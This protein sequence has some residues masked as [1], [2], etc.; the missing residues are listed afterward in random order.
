MTERPIL[1]SGEMVKAILEG[2][3]TQT[4]RI[5]KFKA[6]EPGL[7]FGW[8]GL[9]VGNYC[10]DV[11]ASGIVLQARRGDGCWEDKTYPLHCP[12]GQPGDR[13]WVRETWKI[14]S[15]WEGMPMDF[16]YKADGAICEENRSGEF[17]PNYE[18]WFERVNW[19]AEKYL[20]K[21]N[22][23]Q[24]EE[25]NYIWSADKSPLPWQPSIFMPRWAS[26]LTLEIVK[27]RVERVQEI[28]DSDIMAEGIENCQYA[29][30]PYCTHCS[31]HEHLCNRDRFRDLWDSI[32]AKRGYSWESNPWVWVIEFKRIP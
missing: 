7:N 28:S 14:A 31:G 21:S 11:P 19:N 17:A 3:K 32:N 18:E 1:F 27:V 10:T 5:A 8:S 2:R 13:L 20:K 15:F 25:G 16:Q 26:R 22:C 29:L 24:D 23:E 30:P 12:Y 6:R 4:R 9:E